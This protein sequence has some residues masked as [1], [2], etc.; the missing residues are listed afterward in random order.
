MMAKSWQQ[1]PEAVSVIEWMNIAVPF[2]CF[3]SSR[4]PVSG[5]THSGRF[6]PPHVLRDFV[7]QMILL[8]VLL[9]ANTTRHTYPASE[10]PGYRGASSLADFEV[11]HHPL[12][13]QAAR[14]FL[15]VGPF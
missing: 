7:S 10:S 13:P 15:F 6:F 2:L 9:T 4:I 11:R 8:S 1:K 14:R 5:A 3:Q 12:H